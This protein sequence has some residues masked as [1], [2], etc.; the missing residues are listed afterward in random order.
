V[1][2]FL[3]RLKRVHRNWAKNEEVRSRFLGEV[4]SPLLS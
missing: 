1:Q 4:R 3:Q 2:R